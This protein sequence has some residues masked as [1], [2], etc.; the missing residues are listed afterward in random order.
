MKNKGMQSHFFM[1]HCFYMKE[2]WLFRLGN[3]VDIFLKLNT[4]SLPIKVTIAM[5]KLKN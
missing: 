1:E 5:I 3:L 2:L 4:E